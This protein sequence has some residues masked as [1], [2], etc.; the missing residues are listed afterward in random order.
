MA[1]ADASGLMRR[2]RT[3]RTR[4]RNE[5]YMFVAFEFDFD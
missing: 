2:E 3:V 1:G 5:V 4:V